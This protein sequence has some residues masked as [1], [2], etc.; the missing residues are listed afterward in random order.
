ML[1]I[2]LLGTTVHCLPTYKVVRADKFANALLAMMVMT[3]LFN[4]LRMKAD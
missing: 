1:V 2:R 4:C 3:L